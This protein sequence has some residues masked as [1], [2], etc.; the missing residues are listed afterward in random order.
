MLYKLYEEDVNK[1]IS[2]VTKILLDH[3]HKII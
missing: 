3:K 2:K 1:I